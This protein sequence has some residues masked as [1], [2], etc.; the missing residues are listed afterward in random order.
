[1]KLIKYFSSLFS[2][3]EF[4]I[5]ILVILSQS[6]S[7]KYSMNNTFNF[8]SKI[9]LNFSLKILFLKLICFIR[10]WE[11]L[12]LSFLKNSTTLLLNNSDNL[13]GEIKNLSC[14]KQNKSPNFLSFEQLI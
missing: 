4:P 5:E 6:N 9:S 7:S 14:D 13:F 8:L 10:S 2:F 11:L 1:M 3:V 12:S